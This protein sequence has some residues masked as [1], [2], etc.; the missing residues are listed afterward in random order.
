MAGGG[1]TTTTT[2]PWIEQQDFLEEGFGA[3]KELYKARP[4]GP[5]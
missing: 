3:A 1:T 5:A 4:L 2:E